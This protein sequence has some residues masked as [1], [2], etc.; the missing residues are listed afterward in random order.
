MYICMS[1]C[2][3]MSIC[4]HVPLSRHDNVLAGVQLLEASEVHGLVEQ[5]DNVWVEGLPVRV[6]EVILLAL[7]VEHARKKRESLL[8]LLVFLFSL[9]L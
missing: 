5:G 3:N 1:A 6:L 9:F 7:C 2:L 8:V 4:L